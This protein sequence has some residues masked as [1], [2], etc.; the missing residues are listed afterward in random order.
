M[1]DV[2]F[3]IILSFVDNDNF[4][5]NCCFLSKHKNIQ[6]RRKKMNVCNSAKMLNKR[7]HKLPQYS[8][9][10]F[11]L[12]L[13]RDDFIPLTTIFKEMIE[14]L[15]IKNTYVDLYNV[16]ND[17]RKIHVDRY[18][19]SNTILTYNVSNNI[20]HVN[21]SDQHIIRDVKICSTYRMADIQRKILIE[22]YPNVKALIY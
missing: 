18:V 6:N 1:D 16:S 19:V 14:V 22:H 17:I 7:L 21:F 13:S 9:P 11:I 5:S 8:V 10:S 12:W 3:H 15:L 4:M 20:S 2:F